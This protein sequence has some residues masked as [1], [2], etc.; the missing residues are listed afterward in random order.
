MDRSCEGEKNQHHERH[1]SAGEPREELPSA[2][3]GLSATPTIAG[4]EK[5]FV[6]RVSPNVKERT[7]CGTVAKPSAGNLA[8]LAA[9]GLAC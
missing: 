3:S 5:P 1:E 7:P 6:L 2:R 9:G 4:S 8:S